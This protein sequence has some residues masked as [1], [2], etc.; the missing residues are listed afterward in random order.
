MVDDKLSLML[1]AKVDFLLKNY[2]TPPIS[3]SASLPALEQYNFQ[4]K[5]WGQVHYQIQL[6]L[7]LTFH[8]QTAPSRRRCHISHNP[9]LTVHIS[10]IK[11]L[12]HR[13]PAITT[14]Q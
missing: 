1:L 10:H 3:T 5:A 2:F 9:I 13:K 14:I 8:P 7:R 4:N 12:S 11:I 6:L